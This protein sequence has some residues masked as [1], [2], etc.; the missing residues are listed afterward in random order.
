[1]KQRKG[2]KIAIGLLAVITMLLG[3]YTVSYAATETEAEQQFRSLYLNLLETGDNSVQDIT[4]LHL[5]YMTCRKIIEDVKKNEGF[6]PYQ[7]YE[8]NNL[9]EIDS[10]KIIEDTPYLY[11]FH[12]SVNDTGFRERYAAV[13]QMVAEQQSNLDEK[14]T[15]LDKLLWFH[16]Y[17][18]DKLCYMNTEKTAEHL[19]GTSLIQGYGVCQGYARA[20]AIFLKAENIPCEL[21]AGGAH[22][23]LT[24][25]IDGKW[26]HVDPTWD[27]TIASR[28]G[29]HYFLMRNDEEFSTTLSRLHD[30]WKTN[31]TFV[32]ET[33]DVTSN[34]TKYTDWYVHDVWNRM[35]YYDGYWYYV[36]NDAVRKNNIQGSD[37]TVICEG[38][39]LAVTEI[40]DGV[41]S[42]TQDGK[43]EKLN[44]KKEVST[45]TITT[46]PPQNELPPQ[47]PNAGNTATTPDTG[48]TPTQ[49]ISDNK[50]LNSKEHLNADMKQIKVGKPII[51]SVTNKKGGKMKIVL[52]KK[53]SGTKGYEVVYST[54]KKFKNL[55]KKLR[56]T[57]KSKTIGK[58]KKNKTYYIKVR[59]YK[60]T[61]D[62][63]KVYGSYSNIKKVKIKK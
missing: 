49:P 42:Y 41:L 18:V 13:K 19:G 61:S 26:Y 45:G 6:L 63:K 48:A 44:F 53:V 40:K 29:T 38:K 21:V 32:D 55:V 39:N 15:D 36:S 12:L 58:L 7:C 52:G 10:I 2:M 1:M 20:L 8:E 43:E 14:M 57:G 3:E 47:N 31:A 25:K 4:D 46:D 9:I 37:E 5:P 23:W 54:S 16:E 60:K 50:N 30:K 51:K 34:S 59:A 35:Y 33:V 62:G 17:V 24:V 56:F 11:K 27:D 28:L 22:E